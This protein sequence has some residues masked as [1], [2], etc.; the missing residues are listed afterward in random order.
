MIREY[1]EES[2]ADQKELFMKA[3]ETYQGEEGRNDD[4]TV[5]ALK[6]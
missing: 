1:G 3:L 2:M 4:I 5:V 6:I